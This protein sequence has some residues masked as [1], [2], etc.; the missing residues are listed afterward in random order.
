MDDRGEYRAVGHRCAVD[1]GALKLPISAE[2][3]LHILTGQGFIILE[4]DI[5]KLASQC[6]GT[7]SYRR[8]A[9][10]SEAPIVVDCSSF[11]KWLYGERGIWLPRRSIQQREKGKVVQLHEIVGGDLIFVSGRIDY[12]LDDPSDGVGHV[13]IVTD[14]KTVIHAANKQVG[15]IETAV[16]SFIGQGKFRGARRYVSQDQR[17]LTL[18]TPIHREIETADDI[19]WIIM[20]SLPKKI[21][22]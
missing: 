16:E 1:L 19:R 15:V 12:W 18:E 9:R 3:A 8:G 11:T 10:P 21:P 17:I 13:G 7:S 20:Q 2:E 4:V 5:L 14:Y 6:I 22:L